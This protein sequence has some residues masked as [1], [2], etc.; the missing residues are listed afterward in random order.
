MAW[1]LLC[2]A[3]SR[4]EMLFFR[5]L[6]RSAAERSARV[7]LVQQRIQKRSVLCRLCVVCV[8]VVLRWWLR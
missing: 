4:L 5:R 1:G 7:L 6:L 8:A 2:G 3:P